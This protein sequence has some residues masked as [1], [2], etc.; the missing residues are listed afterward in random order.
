[1]KSRFLIKEICAERKGSGESMKCL[2]RGVLM[3][4]S[5]NCYAEI[6]LVL[7][8]SFANWTLFSKFAQGERGSAHVRVQP[9]VIAHL[10]WLDANVAS[11]TR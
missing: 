4:V 7:T 2:M 9:F 11:E 3:K 5:E 10:S 6:L 8:C 1:M